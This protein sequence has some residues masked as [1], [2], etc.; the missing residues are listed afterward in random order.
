MAST[1][2]GDLEV[3]PILPYWPEGGRHVLFGSVLMQCQVIVDR[4]KMVEMV[5]F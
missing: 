1:T 3:E 2:V 5:V 4:M